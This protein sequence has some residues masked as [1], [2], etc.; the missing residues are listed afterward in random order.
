MAPELFAEQTLQYDSSIDVFALGLVH[1]VVL[2]YNE[3]YPVTT[4]LS[5]NYLISLNFNQQIILRYQTIIRCFLNHL[6]CPFIQ[7]LP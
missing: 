7:K 6:Y 5:S 3:E 4:P 2:D 1:L